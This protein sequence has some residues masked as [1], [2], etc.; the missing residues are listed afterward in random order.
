M[1]KSRE[2]NDDSMPEFSASVAIPYDLRFMTVALDWAVGLAS[3]AGGVRK[4]AD[5]L[6][7]ALD[8]TLT[9]LSIPIRMPKYGNRFSWNLPFRP[10]VWPK[11]S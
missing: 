9:F 7:L 10:T 4:E 8:E 1:I 6:R 5:A 3:L 11:S 2:E